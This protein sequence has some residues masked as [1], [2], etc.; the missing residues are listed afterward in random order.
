[1]Q[2][3]CHFIDREL[4]E[5]YTLICGL[6]AQLNEGP[7]DVED[8]PSDP[9]A[10]RAAATKNELRDS[11]GKG[12]TLKKVAVETEEALLRMRLMSALV[13]G[14]QHAHG[15]SLVSLIHNYTFNGDPFIRNFT[16]RLL[17][18]VSVSHAIGRCE[19]DH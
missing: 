6:E 16:E 7:A 17:E 1:M 3:L 11:A 2:S 5:Y 8:V 18:E 12:L 19:K 4:S 13:E 14:A 10:A 9:V 15:G